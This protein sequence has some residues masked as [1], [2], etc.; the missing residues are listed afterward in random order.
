M[1]QIEQHSRKAQGKRDKPQKRLNLTIK[2]EPATW[3]QSW[4]DRGLVISTTD[5]VLLAFRALHEKILEE[6]LKEAQLKTLHD[7]ASSRSKEE[8]S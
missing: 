5:A 3:L 7:S 1:N 2:G 6:D 4:I 8:V